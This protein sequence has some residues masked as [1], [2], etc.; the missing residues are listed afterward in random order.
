VIG[1]ASDTSR[2]SFSKVSVRFDSGDSECAGWLYRPDRPRAAPL[3]VMGPGLAAERT[4]G[5]P[6]L[7]EGLAERG[8][9]TLLFDY[10]RFGDS[11]G[12]PRGVVSIPEQ[13]EDWTAAIERA[14]RLDGV[15]ADRLALWGHSLGGGHALRVAAESRRVDAVIAH[16]PIVDGRALLRA[17]GSSWLARALLS[18]V[19]DRVSG[20][21]GRPHRIPVVPP[22]AYARAGG[23]NGG[24]PPSTAAA[25]GT[26][27]ES[28]TDRD[29]EPLAL[30]PDGDAAEA[31][32]GLVPLRSDWDNRVRARIVLDLWTYRPERVA[33]DLTVPTLLVTGAD[34]PIVP[35]R[36]VARTSR[37]L[38]QGSFLA[39][40]TDHFSLFTDPWRRRLLGHAATFLADALGD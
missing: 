23:G 16:S 27:A 13:L 6:S 5:Y 17:N 11:E 36:P 3:V 20:L 8:V 14:A 40:P 7:A 22:D 19:R 39:L 1:V 12:D 21:V 30:L 15:D 34:D 4:F 29:R 24:T 38:S 33:A 2:E 32:A 31:L 9:A 35:A 37:Q 10:R 26:E 25:T 18:G 28:G